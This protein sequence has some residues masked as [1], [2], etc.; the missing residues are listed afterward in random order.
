MKICYNQQTQSFEVF[1]DL[2]LYGSGE[3]KLWSS[4]AHCKGTEAL[5]ML[6]PIEPH[7]PAYTTKEVGMLCNGSMSFDALSYA[8]DAQLGAIDFTYALSERITKWKWAS[9]AAYATRDD[10]APSRLG[11]NFSDEL[12]NDKDGISQENAVWVDG[13]V[14]RVNRVRFDVPPVGQRHNTT[15][16]IHTIDDPSDRALL[17]Q[18]QVDLHFTPFGTR[19]ENINMGVIASAFVQPYGQFRGFVKV[20]SVQGYRQFT[21]RDVYGVVE[22]HYARW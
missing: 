10:D 9:F 6:Y 7:R 13:A 8:F 1:S 11:I 17:P 5:A 16:H 21:V 20:P 18:V 3:S 12:Y 4:T 2:T 19:E 22:D 15:W 14:Y